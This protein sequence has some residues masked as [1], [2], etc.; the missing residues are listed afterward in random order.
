M[1]WIDIKEKVPIRGQEVL[2]FFP[3]GDEAARFVAP[4]VYDGEIVHSSYPNSTAWMFQ[5]TYWMPYPDP[6]NFS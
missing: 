2:G 4:A 1:E 3:E 5:A 6:P